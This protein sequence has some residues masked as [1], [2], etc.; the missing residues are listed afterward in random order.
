MRT[1][2]K[3][4]NPTT[5]P[6]L[7]T[8]SYF[9]SQRRVNNTD[10]L[11][12]TICCHV[13]YYMIESCRITICYHVDYYMIESCRITICCHVDYY[14]IESCRITICCHVDYYMIESC[15]NGFKIVYMHMH[16][17]LIL[18]LLQFAVNNFLCSVNF[19]LILRWYGTN[20]KR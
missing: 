2:G 17:F 7:I 11:R 3:S 6:Q 9:K 1:N 10:V 19:S 5:R 14:M 18:D 4:N 13:D 15:H 8:V 12:I 16:I 20:V